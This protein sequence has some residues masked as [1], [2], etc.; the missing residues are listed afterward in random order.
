MLFNYSEHMQELN[1]AELFGVVRAVEQ[2][3]AAVGIEISSSGELPGSEGLGVWDVALQRRDAPWRRTMVAASVPTLSL[4][5]LADVRWPGATGRPRLLL[6]SKVSPRS[7]DQLR[8]LGV[9][10]VDTVGNIFIRDESLLI[11]VRRS[12]APVRGVPS[13]NAVNV[14]S[15]KRSQVLFA[16][17]TWPSLVRAPVRQLAETSGVSVGLAKEVRDH[18]EARTGDLR[19]L[20]PGGR[21]RD[22]FVE[23]WAAAFL[24]GLGSM[25][26]ARRFE[27][28]S[29]ELHP[30]EGVQISVSGEVASPWLRNPEEM[31]L[32]VRPWDPMLPLRQRWRSGGVPNVVVRNTFWQAPSMSREPIRPAPPLLIYAELLAAQNSRAREAAGE[33]RLTTELIDE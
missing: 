19:E 9:N 14:F 22:Q 27:A 2:Q 23:Q 5:S 20:W 6:G 17:L 32:W 7:A 29:F 25:R 8:A 1:D 33:V 4:G 26:R 28:R 21:A 10:F 16:L 31:S 18:L 11:D 3:L 15:T 13:P 24:S 12:G 30:M